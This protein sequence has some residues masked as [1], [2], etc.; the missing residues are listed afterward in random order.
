MRADK[1]KTMFRRVCVAVLSRYGSYTALAAVFLG[2]IVDAAG[3]IK[4]VLVVHCRTHELVEA[5][6]SYLGSGYGRKLV[7]YPMFDLGLL[8]R[9][10]RRS[11]A[12]VFGSRIPFFIIKFAFKRL[13]RAETRD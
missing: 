4:M 2:R 11:A 5:F 12:T 7:E 8:T 9:S 6:T 3:P 1:G 10:L 13:K